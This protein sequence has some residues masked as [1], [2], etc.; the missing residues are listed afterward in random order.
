MHDLGPGAQVAAK[1]SFIQDFLG[2]FSVISDCLQSLDGGV[3]LFCDLV[4][5]FLDRLRVCWEVVQDLLCLL[6]CW[7]GRFVG[8]SRPGLPLWFHY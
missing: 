6:R 4:L 7:G 2:L 8:P 3:D 5:P 1:G